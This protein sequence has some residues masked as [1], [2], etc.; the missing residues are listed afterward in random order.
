MVSKT[1]FKSIE[2]FI[3]QKSPPVEDLEK[4]LLKLRNKRLRTINYAHI[5]TIDK[6]LRLL[7]LCQTGLDFLERLENSLQIH[8]VDWE[9]LSK[10]RTYDDMVGYGSVDYSEIS[11]RIPQI[12]FGFL[13]ETWISME[14]KYQVGDKFYEY[15]S[16]DKKAWKNLA[17]QSGYC[18][19]RGNKILV[20]MTTMRS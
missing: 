17:G 13:N 19:V 18:L 11:T 8:G 2:K 7:K 12:M 5:P 10:E 6:A 3:L 16:V 9:M 15:S 4:F 1:T 20:T 14:E